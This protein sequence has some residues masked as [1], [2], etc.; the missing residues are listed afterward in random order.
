MN[1][2]KSFLGIA[3]L[4]LIGWLTVALYF[5][6][7]ISCW[8]MARKLQAA[9]N[10]EDQRELR[11][12][13]SAAAAVLCLGVTKLLNLEK[14]LTETSRF[15][16][17]SQGWYDHR[18]IVQISFMVGM[19]IIC[20]IAAI[21]LV[22]WARNAPVSTWLALAATTMLICYCV[23]RAVSLHSF[24]RLIDARILGIRLNSILEIGG[25]GAVLLA[26]YWRQ[27]EIRKLKP[28]SLQKRA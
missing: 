20:V 4:T 19:A 15:V 22:R 2:L 14:A 12:W 7:A 13:D 23:I 17:R 10:I 5:S 1:S 3:E 27:S 16:A 11:G 21:M 28:R 6:T 24:D 9:A 18:R 26:S 25:I 8:I